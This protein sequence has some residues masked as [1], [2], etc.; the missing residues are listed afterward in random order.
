MGAEEQQTPQRRPKGSGAIKGPRE[1]D[2]FYRG[3]KLIDGQRL[4]TPWYPMVSM[5]EAALAIMR[6]KPKVA[7]TRTLRDAYVKWTAEASITAST[8]SGYETSMRN[9]MGPFLDMPVTEVTREAVNA[10]YKAME[11]SGKAIST[12]RGASAIFRGSLRYA[13]DEGWIP[14]NPVIGI[15]LPAA[16]AASIE[17]IS[18]ADRELIL[19]ELKGHRLE[20]RY[21]LGIVFMM[22]PAEVLGLRWSSVD[23]NKGT[24]KVEGQLQRIQFHVADG[25]PLGTIY[26]RSPKTRQGNRTLWLDDRTIG[27]LTVWKKIQAAEAAEH[28]DTDFQIDRRAAQAK[29]LLAAKR[30]QLLSNPELYDVA[31]DDLVFT[32]RNGDPVLPRKDADEWKAILVGLKTS[33]NRLYSMR[34]SAVNRLI[35][36][37]A[38]ID[39]VSVSAG[40]S[41]PPFTVTKYGGNR[42]DLSRGLRDYI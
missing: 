22:R 18:D 3:S 1:G 21:L 11:R 16:P 19:G 38:P 5:V 37:G 8:R 14:F 36:N 26:K 17:E 20:A 40:H 39:A 33:H 29:R 4:Y 35:R 25:K 28:T 42:S 23:L 32:L 7:P 30:A 27:A 34:H 12:I 10:H 24:L 9:Y 6:A 15:R 2:G 13:H 31:P 41:S